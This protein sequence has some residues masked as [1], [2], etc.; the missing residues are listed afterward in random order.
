MIQIKNL[1]KSFDGK[2]ILKGINLE[3]QAGEIVALIGASGGGKSTLL[4]CLCQLETPSEGE[5]WVGGKKLDF[6]AGTHPSDVGMVFQNFHLFPHLNVMQ[7]LTY[8]PCRVHQLSPQAAEEKADQLLQWAGL[9]S[10]KD[11]YPKT[12]SGGEKQRVSI[13]RALMMNPK[14]MLF[15]EPT[16][17]LD[18]ERVDSFIDLVKSLSSQGMTSLIIT[19]EMSF[20]KKIAHRVL[21]LNEG[22]LSEKQLALF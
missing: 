1:K 9:S 3:V 8:A 19:H 18:A 7:N 15:D 12:L 14:V 10:R 20:V 17:A 6:S 13:L 22:E 4:R 5:I 21:E 11:A 16:S 2:L